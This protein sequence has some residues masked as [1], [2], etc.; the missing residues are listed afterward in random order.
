MPRTQSSP[1]AP[2]RGMPVKEKAIV[3]A[4]AIIQDR[5]RTLPEDARK[6]LF[7]LIALLPRAKGSD[8]LTEVVEAIEEILAQDTVSLTSVS[9]AD[10]PAPEGLVNWMKFVGKRIRDFREKAGQT[11]GEL[12]DKA[13]LPQSH[14]SRLENAKHSATRLTLKK[15]ATALGVPLAELDPSEE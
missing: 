10:Q 8:E 3:C 5:V 11:Q 1:L 15:I 12:A 9:L 14:I 13:E 4:L 7:K 6:D 2:L